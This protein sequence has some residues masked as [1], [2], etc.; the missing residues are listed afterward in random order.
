MSTDL[1]L[2][3]KCDWRLVGGKVRDEFILL[4]RIVRSWVFIYPTAHFRTS[5]I[6]GSLLGAGI[7]IINKSDVPALGQPELR[8]VRETKKSIW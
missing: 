7:I 5:C 6:R 3:G 8:C 2:Q 1:V 4:F